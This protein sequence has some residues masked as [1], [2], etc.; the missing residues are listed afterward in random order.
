[1][2]IMPFGMS[3]GNNSTSP[4]DELDKT[5]KFYEHMKKSFKEDSEKDKKKDPPKKNPGDILTT[6]MFFTFATPLVMLVYGW[7]MTKMLLE[8]LDALGKIKGLH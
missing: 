2:Y 8:V 1:M 4:I 3:Q 6:A 7:L 5:I